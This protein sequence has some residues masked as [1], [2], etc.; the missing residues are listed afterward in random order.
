MVASVA[1]IGH[2]LKRGVT[3]MK[4]G[5]I[6]NGLAL[7]PGLIHVPRPTRR[8]RFSGLLEAGILQ[9]WTLGV[10]DLTEKDRHSDDGEKHPR[11]PEDWHFHNVQN[12]RSDEQDMS[13]RLSVIVVNW[14]VRDLL[15][16]CLRSL[17]DQMPLPANEWE[18]FVVDN[19]SHDG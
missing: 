8:N 1:G 17:Y 18:L 7:L 2:E 15:H 4:T 10:A 13:M 16:D 19:D 14:K 5:V 11:P 12:R 6:P 3:G 9:R